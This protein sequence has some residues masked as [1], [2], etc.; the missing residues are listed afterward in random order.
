MAN[1]VFVLVASDDLRLFLVTTPCARPELAPAR[2]RS[3]PASTFRDI[4]VAATLLGRLAVAKSR[5]GGGLGG[6]LLADALQR[7]Y[8]SAAIVGSSMVVV[9]AINEHAAAFYEAYGFIR[10]PNSLRSVMPTFSTS[11]ERT[12]SSAAI[13]ASVKSSKPS[14]RRSRRS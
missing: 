12:V 3:Q 7:A 2:F 6:L 4:L 11:G 1:G 5:Q 14:T 13:T 9:D 10:L 8:A